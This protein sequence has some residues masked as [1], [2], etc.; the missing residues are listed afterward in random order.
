VI[1]PRGRFSDTEPFEARDGVAIH[2][3]QMRFEGPTQFHYVLEYAW[4]F[5]ACFALSLRVWRRR[6]FDVIHAGNPPDFFFPMAW[7]YGLF[8]KKFI[9][10]QHD[11]CPETY[12][13]RFVDAGRRLSYR[14][15]QW[16]ERLSYAAA[17]TVIATNE[18][19]RAVAIQRGRVAPDRVF[20][21]RNSPNLA[22]F[23]PMP[24]DPAL[25]EGFPYMVAFV[26]IMAPQDGVDYLLRAAHH[27]V[28]GLGRRDVLFVLMGT[29][30]AWNDLQKM[31]TDLELQPWVRFTG[32][33]PDEPML[34]YLASADVC[35]SPD[36]L[37][38]LNDVSTM[39]KLMEF[40]AMRKPSVSFELKEARFSAGDS[41]VY[42]PSNDWKAF[43]RAIAELLDDPA[44]RERM[45]EAGLQRIRSD[46]SWAN[47]ETQLLAA[48]A[49]TLGPRLAPAGERARL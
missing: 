31:W 6:G 47:S 38:P 10:D 19:Y 32:R 43:A 3:F 2:R 48:Y 18:S 44:R 28:Y 17:D 30:P 25:K 39:T 22:V 4:A 20:V 34:R 46:L 40:M 27:L 29:G 7:F 26:G 9:F 21:V 13:S 37:N 8:G 42:V 49:R 16:T 15:L 36:P 41:A 1:C 23:K 5:L 45:G 12:L 35:A 24:P 33:I 14:L 11:L